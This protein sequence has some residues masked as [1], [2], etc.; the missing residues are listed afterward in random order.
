[1][2]ALLWRASDVLHR[3]IMVTKEQT[4]LILEWVSL[5]VRCPLAY[6]EEMADFLNQLNDSLLLGFWAIDETDGEI[7]F[8]HAVEV[9]GI[10]MTPK[11]I[12]NFAKTTLLQVERRYKGVLAIMNGEPAE[13]AFAIV[14][15]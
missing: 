3:L 4:D 14:G 1:M 7:R 2:I 8:R 6:R 5:D 15:S 12:D 9:T 13:M 10:Q 11:F